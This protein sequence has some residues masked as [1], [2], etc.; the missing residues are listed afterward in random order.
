MTNGVL[1]A[2]DAALADLDE[3]LRITEGLSDDYVFGMAK[4]VLALA[5][6][7]QDS[8]AHRQRGLEL[9]AQARDMCLHHR[10]YLSEMPIIDF[11][12]ALE[13]ARSGDRDGAIPQLRHAVDDMFDGGQLGY[14]ITAN[15]VFAETLIERGA[16]RDVTDAEAA[17]HQL[18]TVS[19]DHGWVISEVWLLRL[20][21]LLARAHGDGAAYADFR[22][23]YRDM[24]RTLGF[25]GHIAWAEAMP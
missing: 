7:H 6:L 20:Y 5:L 16:D 15:A 24:A 17:V 18:A 1:L 21:A 12:T 4:Y 22:D 14:W 3:A 19:A 9:M 13:R 11:S 8:P 2:D 23:R 25:D 10:Y